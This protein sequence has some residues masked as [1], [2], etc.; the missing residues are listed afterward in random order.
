MQNSAI[1]EDLIT[2][3]FKI[4]AEL[5]KKQWLESANER[6]S[7]DEVLFEFECLIM[8]AL[9]TGAKTLAEKITMIELID[10]KGN[11]IE[12]Y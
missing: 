4:K 6:L 5:L 10:E 8:G 11:S 1:I 12:K 3:D 9:I 7:S 2:S